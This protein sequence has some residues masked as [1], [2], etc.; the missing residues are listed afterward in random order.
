MGGV[1]QLGECIARVTGS[2]DSV[3]FKGIFDD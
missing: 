3:R 1:A 2:E